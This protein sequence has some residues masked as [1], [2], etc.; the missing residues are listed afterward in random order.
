[1]IRGILVFK[2]I[3]NLLNKVMNWNICMICILYF[4]YNMSN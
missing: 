3:D 2:V 1:M 4:I